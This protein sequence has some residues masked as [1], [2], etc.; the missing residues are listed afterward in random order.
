MPASWAY[1]PAVRTLSRVSAAAG[2]PD[3]SDRMGPGVACLP[4]CTDRRGTAP[5][6]SWRHRRKPHCDVRLQRT[7]ITSKLLLVFGTLR[8]MQGK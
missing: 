7:S 1:G 3:L 2:A 4:F 8:I 6:R 5:K